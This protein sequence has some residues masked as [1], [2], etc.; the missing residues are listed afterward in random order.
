MLE[1][2]LRNKFLLAVFLLLSC[3]VFFNSVKALTV[4][5]F[6]PA[7]NATDVPVTT[8][9]S[10]TFDQFWV[11]SWGDGYIRVRKLSDDS[12]FQSY[13][14]DSMMWSYP[15]TIT[16][17][18]SSTLNISLNSG[19][20]EAGETYYV[21]VDNWMI[22]DEMWMDYYAGISNNTTWR[23]TTEGGVDEDPPEIVSLNPP[24][25]SSGAKPSTTLAITFD[26]P[27]FVKSG[28]I[29]IKLASD[30][31][32]V[33][34]ISITSGNVS[35][36]ETETLTIS[37]SSPLAANTEYY[38]LID[39]GALSDE[40]DNDFG[41]IAN[42]STWSFTTGEAIGG[43][44]YDSNWQY[45]F[46]ISVKASKVPS[47]LTDFPV[48]VNL[49]DVPVEFFD[50]VKSDGSDIRV[51]KSDGITE[52]AREIVTINTAGESGEMHFLAEGTLSS[53]MDTD[54]FIYYGNPSATEPAASSDYGSENVWVNNYVGVWHLNDSISSVSPTVRDS[55]SNEYHGTSY[56][57][58]SSSD[59]VSARL[60]MGFKFDGSNDYIGLPNMTSQFSSTATLSVWMKSVNS[61][62]S[63]TTRTGFLQFSTASH[64]SH[65]PW[66]DNVLYINTFRNDRLVVGNN[67]S[68]NKANWHMLNIS[69]SSGTNNYKMYQNA[70]NFYS[71]T[72]QSSISMQAAP[73]LAG[74]TDSFSN[75]YY[76][77]GTMDEFRLSSVVRSSAWIET[78]YENQN[79]PS[80]FYYFGAQEEG[81]DPTPPVITNLNP[82]DDSV[83]V[84]IDTN[85]I[86]EFNEAID[87][88]TGNLTI[89]LSSNDSVFETISVSSGQV[90][91]NGTTTITINPNADLNFGTGYYVLID[92][93]AFAD[94]SGNLFAG[95]SNKTT[96]NFITLE[97][98]NTPWAYDEWE[99]RL[100]LTVNSSQVSSDLTEFPVYVNMSHFPAG[101][102]SGAKSDGGD[103]RVSTL[104]GSPCAT[105]IVAIDTANGTGEMHFKAPL[106]S[107]SSDTVFW[108]Y[109]NNANARMLNG[110]HKYGS[111]NVWSNGYVAVYHMHED[112]AEAGALIKDSTRY[113]NH[114][115]PQGG[116]TIDDSVVGYLGN[117]NA[118][119]FD[120]ANDYINLGDTEVVDFGTGDFEFS[121]WAKTNNTSLQQM[122]FGKD[123]V[124][125]RQFEF[126]TSGSGGIRF[127]YWTSASMVYR[128]QS[129]ILQDTS[130]HYV[131]ALKRGTSFEIYQ[132]GVLAGSG[133][134]GGSHGSVD[135]TSA[136]L[137]IASREYSGF[138]SY[139]DGEIDEARIANRANSAAWINAVYN[140]QNNPSAFY[141]IEGSA[142]THEDTDEPK[143]V[144]L[145]P[146]NASSHVP[147]ARK[148][149]MVFNRNISAGT[150]NIVITD[151][152]DESTHATL[153]CNG[154]QVSISGA[155]VTISPASNFAA[156][157]TYYVTVPSTCFRD[158]GENYYPGITSPLF[159]RFETQGAK[160]PH[161]MFFDGTL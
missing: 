34:V 129:N 133:T 59:V 141:T 58:M 105:E 27:V 101:F 71:T 139:F 6:S 13:H 57:G 67:S 151:T 41:G 82:A 89:L 15:A 146:D 3:G 48:F 157:K 127:S 65:Y 130:W 56:G 95:I 96:W 111:Q 92:S 11:W 145:V 161:P 156:G 5:S 160:G 144:S 77:D 98:I 132:D 2:I 73:R 26:E 113:L 44:W 10:I 112:P 75:F 150:G 50:N 45:R 76:Y 37:L 84:A 28:N 79:A 93:S 152:S 123:R 143:L 116:M 42:S 140:N 114:G 72:G 18:W 9:L 148:L 136:P 43:S 134:T 55:T 64:S 30:D 126:R 19:D 120:G 12:V 83:D 35:G 68:F 122:L 104:D 107:S 109:Y 118:L 124:G 8:N 38:V 142:E 115:T 33:E 78:E 52:V 4:S 7:N 1:K 117:G 21:T 39:D 74:G 25:S 135:A 131:V 86:I 40:S 46:W 110:A 51:T 99:S 49:A 24:N 125:A 20:L 22:M 158:A 60:G 53:S 121:A 91:G 17:E 80:E 85:L 159:W 69:T 54:F 108:V 155:T 31:S 47:N 97:D 66:T 154:G 32:N 36:D 128:D 147:L 137:R 16:G 119:D 61:T 90:T 62:P 81:G 88:Q 103:I 94:L 14:F 149:Q 63:V 87:I 138:E 29:T 23:F 102:F 106:L 70:N 100:R 153:A